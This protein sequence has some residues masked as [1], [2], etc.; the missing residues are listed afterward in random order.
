M[1]T[2]YEKDWKI[3]TDYKRESREPV[4]GEVR[5]ELQMIRC[6]SRK[7]KI[8]TEE[9]HHAST[10]LQNLDMQVEGCQK[11]TQRVRKIKPSSVHTQ[12]H[13]YMIKVTWFRH[14]STG[15]HQ[16]INGNQRISRKSKIKYMCI[17][18]FESKNMH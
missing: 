6:S 15:N 10:A 14:A 2:K 16:N 7:S 12:S 5:N 13:V 17:D 9:F 18:K 11:T 4:K 8:S 1:I 3:F